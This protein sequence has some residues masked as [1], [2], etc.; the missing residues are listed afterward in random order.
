MCM[1]CAN[2]NTNSYPANTKH[3]YNIYTSLYKYYTNVLCLLGKEG[4]HMRMFLYLDTI[5]VDRQNLTKIWQYII[6]FSAHL[7]ASYAFLI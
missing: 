3:F 1:L 4:N 2:V 5:R 6:I 7:A